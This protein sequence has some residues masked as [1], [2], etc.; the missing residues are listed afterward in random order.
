[1]LSMIETSD[2]DR[3]ETF[4]RRDRELHVYELGDLDPFFWPATSWWA[5]SRSEDFAALALLYR[6]PATGTLLLLERADPEAARWLL[7]RV[8][9]VLPDPFYSHLSPGLADALGDRPRTSHG[10]Y[11]KLT[12]REL[13]EVDTT[14]VERL[15]LAAL[16]ALQ[17]LYARAYP[18]NWFDPRMLETGE[19]FG[20]RDDDRIVGVAGVHVVS[21]AHGVAALGNIVT[22]PMHRGRGIA[23]RCTAALCRSLRRHVDTIS[24]NVSAD[25][26]PALR[27]YHALG[28]VDAAVYEEWMVGSR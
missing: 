6:G 5:A 9:T 26:A 12:L 8:A 19:Y 23:R 16:P 4:L 7:E 20:I 28:F 22:D 21:P 17:D 11:L 24:L 13:P 2:R 27:C 15:G 14:G 3:I 10:T 25:N 18:S 1:M